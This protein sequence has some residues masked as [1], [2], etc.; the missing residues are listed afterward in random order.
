MSTELMA[1]PSAGGA[2]GRRRKPPRSAIAR[3]F[4]R[5]AAKP[6][7][8]PVGAP[9]IGAGLATTLAILVVVAGLAVWAVFYALVL[10]GFQEHRAQGTLYD[11]LRVELANETA[12]TGGPIK[13]GAPVALISSEVL[14]LHNAVIVEGT[15]SGDLQNGPGHRIDTPL[16]GQPGVSVLFGKSA[17]FG[18]PFGSL[19]KLR[20]GNVI[21]STTQQ[22]T[23]TYKVLDVRVAGDPFPAPIT[24]TQGRLTLVGSVGH[25]WR[26][27]WAPTQVVYVDADLQ[28]AG[29]P[30]AGGGPTSQPVDQ[31]VMA[32]DTS[33]LTPLVLWLELLLV[34]AVAFVWS[35]RHWGGPQ[36]WLVGAPA[37]IAVIWLV[38]E[39][40]T[41]LVPNLL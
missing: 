32:R 2:E 23:F 35:R 15:T 4:E 7:G 38:T 26:S 8:E 13:D 12:P 33:D 28:G 20:P 31:A 40:A 37:L 22:G 5:P 19:A 9:P 1:S 21:T 39:S 10:S 3:R 18:A 17:T 34:A 30:G 16:P 27:G 11:N 29:K 24:G 14:G 25:G 36:V 6:A 41:P